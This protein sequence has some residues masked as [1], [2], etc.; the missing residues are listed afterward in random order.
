MRPRYISDLPN[1]IIA[2]IFRYLDMKSNALCY[3]NVP[4]LSCFALPELTR[5]IPSY[6]MF[7]GDEAAAVEAFTCMSPEVTG[8][9]FTYLPTL[10]LQSLGFYE[11]GGFVIENNGLQVT[12][13]SDTDLPRAFTLTSRTGCHMGMGCAPEWHTTFMHV[14]PDADGPPDGPRGIASFEHR[15][16]GFDAVHCNVIRFD[17]QWFAE[18]L[19]A[20]TGLILLRSRELCSR[21]GA[22]GASSGLRSRVWR[23][24]HTSWHGM[25]SED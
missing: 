1:E 5:R 25:E 4:E 20:R 6:Q 18:A 11:R 21:V 24:A 22:K 17:L 3:L 2:R 14:V 10:R 9:H 23:E 19:C 13:Q 8:R 7:V 15:H 12:L 16:N